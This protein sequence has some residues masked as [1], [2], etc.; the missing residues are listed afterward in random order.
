MESRLKAVVK[1]PQ[2]FEVIQVEQTKVMYVPR[3]FHQSLTPPTIFLYRRFTVGRFPDFPESNCNKPSPIQVSEII[4]ID[5]DLCLFCFSS[6]SPRFKEVRATSFVLECKKEQFGS[7]WELFL[8]LLFIPPRHMYRK[9][10]LFIVMKATE[11]QLIPATSWA[12]NG[13]KSRFSSTLS[14]VESMETQRNW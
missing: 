13:K 6:S 7:L 9:H 11:R 12:N 2:A 4:L 5:I 1:L 14:A 8:L 3:K 10:K